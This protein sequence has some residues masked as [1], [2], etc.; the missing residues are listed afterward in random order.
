MA[1]ATVK[2]VSND[3][4]ATASCSSADGAGNGSATTCSIPKPG[5]NEIW[6]FWLVRIVSIKGDSVVGLAVFARSNGN[7][8]IENGRRLVRQNL[9]E[10]CVKTA[11]G[12][13]KT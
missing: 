4:L 12:A 6:R 9:V 8:Q 2:S 7:S 5:A 10:V 3:Y 13:T 1:R 11:C